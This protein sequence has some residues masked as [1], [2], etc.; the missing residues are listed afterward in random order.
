MH[1]F[2]P[3]AANLIVAIIVAV[4]TVQL[5]IHRFRKEK[6][7]EKRVEA[8]SRIVEALHDTKAFSVVHLDAEERAIDIPADK[9]Q[10]LIKRW[11]TAN[12]AILKAIDVGAFLLSNTALER[13][14][15]YQKEEQKAQKEQGWYSMLDASW[16]AADSCL[17]DLI[18]LPKKTLVHSYWR[19]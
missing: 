10:A 6:W 1:Q 5:S 7:W 16:S 18:K 19:A 13:L 14:Q 9:K 11:K 3:F 2:I 17:K 12:D 15:K 4:L 8:Y